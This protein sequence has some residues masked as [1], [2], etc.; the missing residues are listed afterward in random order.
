MDDVAGDDIIGDAADL[1]DPDFCSRS[2][3]ISEILASRSSYS[4]VA[5]QSNSDE[6]SKTLLTLW[7][8]C[9]ATTLSSSAL[10]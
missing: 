2:S 3:R 8:F 5:C 4:G 1:T 10:F 7:A 9:I 6:C